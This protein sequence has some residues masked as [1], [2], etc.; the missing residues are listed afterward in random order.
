MIGRNNR[1]TCLIE[2][3][4]PIRIDMIGPFGVGKTTLLDAYKLMFPYQ[5]ITFVFE[6]LNRIDQELNYWNKDKNNRAY[7]IQSVY[8]IETFEKIYKSIDSNKIILSDSS[9]LYHHVG[10][11]NILHNQ[12]LINR[13]EYKYLTLLN[14][15]LSLNMPELVG[16]I[17]CHVK[18]T[19]IL[20]RIT[21]RNRH[22]EFSTTEKTIT[23][24]LHQSKNLVSH[25]NVEVLD[26]DLDNIEINEAVKIMNL[27]VN[28]ILQRG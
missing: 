8:Y 27:F 12:G 9:I 1:M 17:Y 28:T 24:L 11:T 6:D 5:H 13:L 7:F 21:K 3:K 4:S 20:S 14:Q 23:S 25:L 26:M 22:Q 10:Y 16:V 18:P 15:Y 2:R 19:T